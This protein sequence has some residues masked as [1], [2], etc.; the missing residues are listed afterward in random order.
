MTAT[1]RKTAGYANPPLSTRFKKGQ[2]GNIKGRPRGRKKTLPYEAVLGQM[3]TIR[4]DG[5]ERKVTAAEAFLL[6]MTKRGLEGDGPA[7][8]ATMAAIEEARAARGTDDEA[9][10]VIIRRMI[11]PGSVNTAL[12]ALRMAAKLDRYRPSARMALEP[13]LVELALARLGDRRL[14]REEQEKV[15]AATRTPKKVRWPEWWVTGSEYRP[16]GS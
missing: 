1:L 10:R 3:V 4:E 15:V 8:R 11:E 12:I 9:I 16:P 7:G 14:S 2:S 6:Q 13:W 5:L